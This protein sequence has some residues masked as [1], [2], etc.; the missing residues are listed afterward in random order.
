[1][2]TTE[3]DLIYLYVIIY[4]LGTSKQRCTTLFFKWGYNNAPHNFKAPSNHKL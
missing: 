4:P 3:A 1:M 2:K